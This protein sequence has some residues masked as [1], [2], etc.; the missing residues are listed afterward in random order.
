MGLFFHNS[1]GKKV[2]VAYA[3]AWP[4][5]PDG[6][7]WA[8][9]GWYAIMPGGTAQA[10]SDAVGGRKFFSSPRRMIAWSNGQ[11]HLSLTCP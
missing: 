1:T 8:K 3:Y 4:A 11:V 5:C 6:G 2:F 10:R 9:K 7:D